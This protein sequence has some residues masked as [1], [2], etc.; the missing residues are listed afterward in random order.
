MRKPES[1]D[2]RTRYLS[3]A[4]EGCYHA[5]C[6][7]L[8]Y[9]HAPLRLVS[10]RLLCRLDIE[11]ARH[12]ERVGVIG[13]DTQSGEHDGEFPA[14]VLAL[15]CYMSSGASKTYPSVSWSFGMVQL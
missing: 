12:V 1:R 11:V 2:S 9:D 8:I 4:S 13:V 10:L 14:D 7:L 15:R 6:L 5:A 3:L